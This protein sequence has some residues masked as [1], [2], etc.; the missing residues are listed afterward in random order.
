[1]THR[2]LEQMAF[3]LEV[4]ERDAQSLDMVLLGQILSMASVE[5]AEARSQHPV[6]GGSIPAMDSQ[7]GPRAPSVIGSWRWDLTCDRMVLDPEVAALIGISREVGASG[8]PFAILI[9]AVHTLDKSRVADT[10]AGAVA[11]DDPLHFVFRIKDPNGATKRIFAVG[12][13]VFEDDQAVSLPGT[14]IDVTD[15]PG[16]SPTAKPVLRGGRSAR[17]NKSASA[18]AWLL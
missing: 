8:V 1:M 11:Q 5:L 18:K 13:A 3:A 16:D 6:V 17:A 2:I 10:F 15:E 9:D 12:R 14:F 4:L 7:Q